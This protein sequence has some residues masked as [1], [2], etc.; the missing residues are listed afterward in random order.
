MLAAMI[1]NAVTIA[2]VIQKRRSDCDNLK[3]FFHKSQRRRKEGREIEPMAP[4]SPE[5]PIP[6]GLHWGANA[7]FR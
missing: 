4:F 6:V 5:L 1:V 7:V 2:T 3:C